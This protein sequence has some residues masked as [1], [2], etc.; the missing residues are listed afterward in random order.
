MASN[1]REL[2]AEPAASE[3]EPD[4]APAS[5]ALRTDKLLPETA[6]GELAGTGASPTTARVSSMEPTE[7]STVVEGAPEDIVKEAIW[8]MSVMTSALFGNIIVI[9]K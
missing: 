3:G 8:A 6:S 9:C 2:F 5:E 7:V 1:S 4:I